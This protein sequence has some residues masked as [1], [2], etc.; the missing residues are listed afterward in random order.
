MLQALPFNELV[1]ACFALPLTSPTTFSLMRL[2][3]GWILTPRRTITA[4][5]QAPHLAGKLHL[6]R[7]HCLFSGVVQ[8][9]FH[10][11][12]VSIST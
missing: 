7:F 4:M 5:L 9:I 8:G 12:I 2:L 6:A 1:L 3:P 11:Q 10:A